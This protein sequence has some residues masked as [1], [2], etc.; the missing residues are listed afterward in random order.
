MVTDL[1][2]QLQDMREEYDGTPMRKAD[3]NVC[4]FA[5]FSNWLL[6]AQ[7]A[8]VPD[9]NAC[10]LGT[11]DEHNKPMARAVLLKGMENEKFTFYTNYRSRK[12]K[13]LQNNPFATMHFPWFSME[14][15]VVVAGR[16]EKIDESQSDEYFKSRPLMSRL[17]A[18]A[19]KQSEFLDSRETLEKA[20]I[21]A[22]EEKGEQPEKPS[23]WGGY[24]LTPESI[25]FWQGGPSRL[26]DRFIY[27]QIE[28]SG[29]WS[30]KRYYP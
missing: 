4:P 12:A 7:N 9:P 15:Q 2:Q 20:F 22:R 28:S 11:V 19:S 8:R 29:K 1:T 26:H 13:H 10:S 21:E 17:G 30:L 23:H 18:W 27:T 3:L 14:R 24:A 5:Q 16:V 25:E 6:D